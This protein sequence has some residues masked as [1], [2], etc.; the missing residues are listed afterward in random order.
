MYAFDCC[1]HRLDNVM[2]E[3]SASETTDDEGP[4]FAPVRSFV[5]THLRQHIP[6]AFLDSAVV[7][8]FG[9]DRNLRGF[10]RTF[11]VGNCKKNKDFASRN[12]IVNSLHD[13]VP[14]PIFVALLDSGII[15][16]IEGRPLDKIAEK[17]WEG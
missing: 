10:E 14:V 8:T 9:Q 17:M 2:N 7:T 4:V 6:D 13:H 5:P 16:I 11:I 1:M 3:V 15:D 12:A